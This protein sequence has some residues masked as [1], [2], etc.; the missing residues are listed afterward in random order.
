M[1]FS[2]HLPAVAAM[3]KADALSRETG[4]PVFWI[5]LIRNVP[6]FNSICLLDSLCTFSPSTTALTSA[7]GAIS[8]NLCLLEC[9]KI[10]SMHY[11]HVIP[12]EKFNVCQWNNGGPQTGNGLWVAFWGKTKTQICYLFFLPS[13]FLYLP[14]PHLFFLDWVGW[15]GGGVA[16]HAPLDPQLVVFT[17]SRLILKFCKNTPHKYRYTFGHG[18]E[19]HFMARAAGAEFSGMSAVYV[20][21][22]HWK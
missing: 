10:V 15:G 14:F 8:S 12:H 1:G 6:N 3:Q 2:D 7:L 11:I 17:K 16:A 19:D 5:P 21:S 22:R 20:S 4:R 9:R 18:A 13:P